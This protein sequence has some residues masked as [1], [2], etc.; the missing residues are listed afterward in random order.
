[1]RGALHSA[2]RGTS[3]AVLR[4]AVG[5]AAFFTAFSGSRAVLYRTCFGPHGRYFQWERTSLRDSLVTATGGCV[6]GGAYRTVAMPMANLYAYRRAH[7]FQ[8]HY[9]HVGLNGGLSES[10]VKGLIQRGGVA[11]ACRTA[12]HGYPEAMLYTMP[13]T[14]VAFLLYEMVLLRT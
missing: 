13:V 1:M 10:W 3:F 5:H 7:R 14:G 12:F 9:G 4:N 2:F 11:G 6:A 8:R